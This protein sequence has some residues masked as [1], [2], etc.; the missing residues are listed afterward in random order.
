V[1]RVD[2]P[3]VG[4]PAYVRAG[5]RDQRPAELPGGVDQPRGQARWDRPWNILPA[6]VFKRSFHTYVL[7]HF[8]AAMP[9]LYRLA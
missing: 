3:L 9:V 1:D 8:H 4:E 5:R 2:L 7:R 6:L